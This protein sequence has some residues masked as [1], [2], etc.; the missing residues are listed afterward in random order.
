MVAQGIVV[1]EN[2]LIGCLVLC[3][4][5]HLSPSPLPF[6]CPPNWA[7]RLM[8]CWIYLAVSYISI[9]IH[10]Y[11]PRSPPLPLPSGSPAGTWLLSKSPGS[12]PVF[13]VCV[14]HF[15]CYG[16]SLWHRQ[17]RGL[18]ELAV[19]GQE[20]ILAALAGTFCAGVWG[21]RSHQETKRSSPPERRNWDKVTCSV[22]SEWQRL[23][24]HTSHPNGSTTPGKQPAGDISPWGNILHWTVNRITSEDEMRGLWTFKS[25]MEQEKPG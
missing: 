12:F 11:T 9:M 1:F 4:H 22:F 7:L 13:F 10:F 25:R 5:L 21:S 20:S 15:S 19:L 23:A 6:L 16:D 17:P 24:Y 14:A 18:F 3:S 8:D 2:C